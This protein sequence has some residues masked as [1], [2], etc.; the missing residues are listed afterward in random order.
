MQVEADVIVS[1]IIAKW[2][3]G[4]AKLDATA[5]ASLYSNNAFFFGSNPKLYRGRD[6]AADY[7]NGLPLWRSS[8]AVFS[9]VQAAQAGPDLINMAAIASFDL[10][11]EGPPLSVKITWVIV[12]EDGDWKIASHH[13]SSKIPLIER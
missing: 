12:R 13:V 4:F 9:E 2:C 3:V 10:G 8:S 11:E 7:F 1:A 5:L 6:G